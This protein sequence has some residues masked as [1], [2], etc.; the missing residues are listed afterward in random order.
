MEI[1][2]DTGII[3]DHTRGT[4]YQ[5]QAFPEFMQKLIHAGGLMNYNNKKE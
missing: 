3:T 4:S 2:F 1:D 5:G